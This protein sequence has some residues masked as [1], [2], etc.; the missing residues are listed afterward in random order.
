[1]NDK[2]VS[3]VNQA[4]REGVGFVEV[5]SEALDFFL[6]DENDRKANFFHYQGIRVYEAGK[7]EAIEAK[8]AMSSEEITFR[9]RSGAV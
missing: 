6:P 9:T 1:M 4:K 7:R 8:E 5:D 2:L 3:L